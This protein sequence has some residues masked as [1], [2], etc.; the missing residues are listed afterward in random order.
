MLTNPVLLLLESLHQRFQSLEDG[1][2]ATYIPELGRANPDHFGIALATADGHLYAVGDSHVPFTIQSISKP[3]VYGLTLD[4]H[5]PDAVLRKVSVEPS[6]E[7]FNAISLEPG[8]GRPRNPMINAGAV[9]VASLV[10]G[11]DSDSRWARVLEMLSA[12]AGRPLDVDEAVYRSE[13][14]TGH[15]N[16]AIGHLLRNANVLE[17][18]VD[19]VCARYFRQCAVSVTCEDLALMAAT[20]ANDGVNPCTGE[21]AIQSANVERVLSVMSTSGMYDAAGHWVYRVGMPAK[22]G[23]GGGVLAVL[24]G[25][26]G[27]AV[28][29]PPLDAAGNSARGVAVCEAL[30]HEFGLHLLRP[31]VSPRSAVRASFRL[32]EAPSTRRRAPAEAALLDAHAD[33]ALV[34]QL[35][36]PLSFATAEAA[37]SETL[38]LLQ[39]GATILFDLARTNGIDP[40]VCRLLGCLAAEVMRGGGVVAF[41]PLAPGDASARLIAESTDARG[42]GLRFFEGVD[43]ATEWCEERALGYE[44]GRAGGAH[45]LSLPHHPLAGLLDDTQLCWLAR[46]ARRRVYRPGDR[47][48]DQAQPSLT[49]YLLVSGLVEVSVAG[50]RARHRLATL[51]PGTCF[52]E[53]ALLD[54]GSRSADVDAV[55]ESVAYE[56]SVPDLDAADAHAPGLRLKLI[57][58]LARDLASRLR[59]ANREIEALAR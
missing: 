43:A 3:F 4:D 56:I 15:R 9:A 49:F 39:P 38:R 44:D 24:P 17:G 37:I 13:L 33:Q 34:V 12:Y 51:D 14:E 2:V 48:I 19:E 42:A 20:L 26:F 35:Q 54:D 18:D 10:N 22:S 6:G 5:G 53:L 1:E 45:E 32:S 55:T 8:T 31:P 28:F 59:R 27:L 25:Q 58:A 36:G 21:R 23:V 57:G 30:S 46:V 16:R 47:I 41:A 50:L 52:G 29:S 11:P 7:A 40:G